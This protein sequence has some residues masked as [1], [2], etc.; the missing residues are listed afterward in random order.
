MF[1]SS[2]VSIISCWVSFVLSTRYGSG[3]SGDSLD[4][5]GALQTADQS[6]CTSGFL[7]TEYCGEASHWRARSA[8]TLASS[9]FPHTSS[10]CKCNQLFECF[11]NFKTL[12]DDSNLNWAVEL[13]VSEVYVIQL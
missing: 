6:D 4:S 3:F 12:K 13:F 5:P 9:P 1:E 7:S 11:Y 10:A 8:L 2:L